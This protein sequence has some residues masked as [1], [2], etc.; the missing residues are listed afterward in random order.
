ME[1]YGNQ[2]RESYGVCLHVAMHTLYIIFVYIRYV[3]YLDML[4]RCE[5][6]CLYRF[7][8]EWRS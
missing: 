5:H 2:C 1:H 3:A 6:F 8:L 4:Y 7:H